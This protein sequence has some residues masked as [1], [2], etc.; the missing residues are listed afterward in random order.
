MAAQGRNVTRVSNWH[1]MTASLYLGQPEDPA[2]MVL[3]LK[4]MFAVTKDERYKKLMYKTFNWFLGDN[5]LG[6]IMYDETTGGCYDGLEE[7]QVNLNQGAESGLL[8]ICMPALWSNKA[9]Q[10]CTSVAGA[11][12][13]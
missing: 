4:T 7:N 6:Q 9:P 12:P 13:L 10:E 11:S 3:A 5:Y 8:L 1:R 2:A